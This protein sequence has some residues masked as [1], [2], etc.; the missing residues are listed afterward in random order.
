MFLKNYF[1]ADNGKKFVALVTT[2]CKQHNIVTD[3][4]FYQLENKQLITIKT[5]STDVSVKIDEAIHKKLKIINFGYKYLDMKLLFSLAILKTLP[6]RR[7]VS[8][9]FANYILI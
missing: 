3:F 4:R 5:Y 8:L 2:N 6:K 7:I 9:L 1:V